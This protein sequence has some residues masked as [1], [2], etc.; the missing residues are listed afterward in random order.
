MG[1][2]ALAGSLLSLGAAAQDTLSIEEAVLRRGGQLSPATLRGFQFCPD[3]NEYSYT[4]G[5]TLFI[6]S[7]KNAKIKEHLLGSTVRSSIGQEAKAEHARFPRYQWESKEQLAVW[8]KGQKF[9]ISPKGKLLR[10]EAPLAKGA[11]NVHMNPKGKGYAF[12][13]GE[14]IYYMDASGLEHV[15]T[16]DTAC[17]IVNGHAVHRNEFGINDG[18]FW[19]PEGNR[20]AFYRMDESMVREY[21]LVTIATREAEARPIRYPMAGMTSHQVTVGIYTPGQDGVV[22]LQTPPPAD[23]YLTNVAFDPEGKYVYVAEVNRA[24]DTM[25]LNRYNASNGRFDRQLF[26]E[27]SDKYVEPMYPVRFVPGRPD[28]FVWQSQRTGHDHLYLYN[29]DG[30]MVS[31][32]THGDW[33]VISLE[34]FDEKGEN[35]Y[36]VSNEYNPIGRDLVRVNMKEGHKT[37]LTSVNGTNTPVLDVAGKRFASFWSTFDNPGGVYAGSLN[38]GCTTPLFT[39]E[40]PLKGY[41]MPSM[42][43]VKI[44]AADGITDLYGRIFYPKN[45]KPGEKYPTIVYVY[46]GPHAQLVHDSWYGR[47]PYWEPYMAQRGY[48]VF[49]LD[50]RGSANRGFAFE[51]MIHRHLGTVEMADQMEGVKYLKG[52]PF[53]DPER[54][55]V[56]G[57]SFG[58][59]MTISL[60][61][62]Q[63]D[64]F[65]VG[66]A[67]GP[68]ID[69]KYY[70]I[71]YGE[72][73]MDTPQE[74]PEGYKTACLNNYVENLKGKR[75]LL[76]Q[77]YQDP[78]VVP[79]HA[80]SYMKACV[81]KRMVELDALLYPGHEHNVR[82]YDRV[83]LMMKVT[84]YF[85]RHLQ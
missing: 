4:K 21:P 15:V 43:L 49:V 62:R 38:G 47:A 85:D 2:L 25:R 13:R 5:D 37:R 57:W 76:L 16:A 35:L 44:K 50:S 74:N 68:V 12:N 45:R 60:L 1:L 10:K 22:W 41:D 82:G 53:V 42:E 66:V 80:L 64:T 51:Q 17:G 40:N 48:V 61:T 27:I 69:W 36:I 34:G 65:K 73:Y 14:A 28:L 46:G 72:R 32:L 30:E 9:I 58:G 18:I 55:G 52:L 56:H 77:G 7:L 3:R 81:D 8:H 6:A 59:F 11:T 79:Q 78:T 54:I 39:A 26:I 63:G 23:H 84:D 31:T 19:A 83:Q 71:M 24:Q 70:E 20:F 33:E 67:G 29:R 75:L